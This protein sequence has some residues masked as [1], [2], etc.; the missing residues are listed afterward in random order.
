MKIVLGNNTIELENA[1][2]SKRYG[3][4]ENTIVKTITLVVKNSVDNNIF[5]ELLG[6]QLNVDILDT[7]DKTI[8]TIPEEYKIKEVYKAIGEHNFNVILEG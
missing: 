6:K 1:Y 2:N 4:I 3:G 7:N 8:Y 5:D